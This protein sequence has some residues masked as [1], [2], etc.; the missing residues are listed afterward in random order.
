MKNNIPSNKS[1]IVHY[2]YIIPLNM[3]DNIPN[4][5]SIIVHHLYVRS[6][7]LCIYMY[8]T[9]IWKRV[10]MSAIGTYF[11]YRL[12]FKHTTTDPRDRDACALEWAGL[13]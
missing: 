1:I 6:L 12:L 5:K 9:S 2:I 11:Y 4:N 7:S 3:K 13:N 10:Y 8:M